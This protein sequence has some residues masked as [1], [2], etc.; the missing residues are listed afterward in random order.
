MRLVI[1][2]AVAVM[3]FSSFVIDDENCLE[4]KGSV[5]GKGKKLDK[6]M[7]TLYEDGKEVQKLE[8]AKSPFKMEFPRN[9]YYSLEIKKEGYVPAIL[10][11]NTEVPRGRDCDFHFQ[12][13]YDMIEEQNSY[14]QDYVDFPAAVVKY[15]KKD[16][17]FIISDKYNTHIKKLIGILK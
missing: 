8:N 5:L 11:I 10:I 2:F 1:L 12:F 17:E 3:V 7:V 15:I 13:E 16:D 9:H 14:N 4:I 6:L